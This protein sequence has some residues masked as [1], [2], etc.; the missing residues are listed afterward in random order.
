MENRS[1]EL[2]ALIK[3]RENL[4]KNA[5]NV[6]DYHIHN[7]SYRII[8]APKSDVGSKI[9]SKKSNSKKS[10]TNSKGLVTQNV[11]SEVM[12]LIDLGMTFSSNVNISVTG[13]DTARTYKSFRF[14][15]QN[16]V[17]STISEYSK[18]HHN[19]VFIINEKQDSIF[20]SSNGIHEIRIVK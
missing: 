10:K 1:K 6:P 7:T 12:D 15:S 4:D 11:K 17:A 3:L 18:D 9:N 14:R 2:L 19:I 8:T 16:Q 20:W 5:K 13:S